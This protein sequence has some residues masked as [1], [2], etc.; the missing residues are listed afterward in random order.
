MLHKI[1][2]QCYKKCINKTTTARNGGEVIMSGRKIDD[3]SFWAG[4]AGK[5]MVMPQGVHTKN[6]SSAEGAGAVSKYEDTTE[7]IKAGQVAGV[8]KIKAHPMKQP[9]YR[10]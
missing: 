2:W 9:N 5:D 7:A 10:N 4:K 6:E 3:H 1:R 8:G